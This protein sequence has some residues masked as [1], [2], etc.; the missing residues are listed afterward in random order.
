MAKALVLK[1]KEATR[2]GSSPAATLV[3]LSALL[4]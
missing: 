1:T 4:I 2:V 3:R